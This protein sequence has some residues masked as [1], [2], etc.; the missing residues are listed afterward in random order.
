MSRSNTESNIEVRESGIHGRGIYAIKKIKK[1]SEIIE[2][3][4]E[5]I[6]E[7]EANARYEDNPSTYLFMVADDIYIDGLSGG[8]D[9]RFINHSCDPNCVAYLEDDARVVIYALKKIKPGDELAYDYQ[10][11]S[12]GLG[13]GESSTDYTCR[14]G[15]ERCKGTMMGKTKKKK[16]KKK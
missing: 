5:R 8:N 15:A 7:E 16:K 3:T 9:A 6:G 13:D 2:Y 12:E 4:G 1:G 10:L 14:C 11:T